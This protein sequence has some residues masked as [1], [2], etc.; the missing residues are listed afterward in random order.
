MERKMLNVKVK[1][2]FCSTI[3]R[4]RTRETDIVEYVTK[5]KGKWTGH[6]ARMNNNRRT[7]RSTKRQKKGARSDGRSKRRWGDDTVGQQ[8]T[9]WTRAAKVRESCRALALGYFL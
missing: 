8:G 5:A 7:I 3:I 4:Q 2:R 1:D 6:I 9:V